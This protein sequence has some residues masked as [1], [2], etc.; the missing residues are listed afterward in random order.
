M[1]HRNPDGRTA[2]SELELQ[3]RLL[4]NG[5]REAT[6]SLYRDDSLRLQQQSAFLESKLGRSELDFP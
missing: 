3:L 4:S 2:A 1:S 5:A 6:E